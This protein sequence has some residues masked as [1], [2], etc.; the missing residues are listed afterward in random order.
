MHS[1]LTGGW[2]PVALQ[3]QR[4]RVRPGAQ[5]SDTP[6]GMIHPSRAAGPAETKPGTVPACSAGGP[7]P[8]GVPVTHLYRDRHGCARRGHESP[9]GGHSA[10]CSPTGRDHWPGRP[11]RHPTGRWP[12][13]RRAVTRRFPPGNL[14]EYRSSSVLSPARRAGPDR[15]SQSDG[16]RD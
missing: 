3:V 13:V 2:P 11:G 15:L 14:K 16:H 7:G 1:P 4:V 10:R 9:A 6:S 12:P 8:G 5:T